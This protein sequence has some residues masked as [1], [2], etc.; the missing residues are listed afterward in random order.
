MKGTS[1]FTDLAAVEAWD[2]WFRWR[3]G[4]QLH[5]IS[6]QDTWARVAHALRDPERETSS[7]L[8]ERQLIEAMNAWQLL[9]DESLLVAAG[10]DAYWSWPSEGLVA[11]LNLA[12]FVHLPGTPDASIDWGRIEAVAALAVR[13]LDNAMTTA[14]AASSAQGSRMRVGMM[15]LADALALLGERYD[16]AYGRHLAHDMAQCLATGCLRESLRLARERGARCGLSRQSTLG[17]KLRQISS[18]MAESAAESGLR[19]VQLTAITSQPRLALLANNVADA[20]DPLLARGHLHTIESGSTTRTVGS[21]GYALEIMRRQGVAS[22]S[23]A[24]PGD[25]ISTEAQLDMRAAMQMWIDEPILYP[26]PSHRSGRTP[27]AA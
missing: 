27:V 16:S 22:A 7:G 13:A 4:D 18:D 21:H 12:T 24:T 20:V 1:P 10:T 19:H 17:Y 23:S 5:D 14:S 15:G 25:V 26:M 6:I 2:A 8:F 11:V 3:Q 9:L